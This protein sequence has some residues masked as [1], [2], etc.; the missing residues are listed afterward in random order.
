[1]QVKEKTVIQMKLLGTSVHHARM[2]IGVRD[3]QVTIDEPVARG[4]TDLGLTPTE[5]LGTALMG[6]LNVI[7]HRVA[8]KLGLD[9][10]SLEINLVMD[11]DRR[12]VTLIEE[13]K[14]PFPAMLIKAKLTTNADEQM[15]SDFREQLACY[16]PLSQMIRASGT[17]LNEEWEVV[18]V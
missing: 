9:I 2:D 18:R 12:G 11:F 4:G 1:M 15:I 3:K 7:G 5:T 8:H 16:C 13:I 6:C 17:V 10:Q 14:V